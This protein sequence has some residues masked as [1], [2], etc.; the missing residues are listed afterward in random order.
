MYQCTNCQTI[1]DPSV[2]DEF[3]SIEAG[4]FFEDLPETYCCSV[5]D[6]PLSEFQPTEMEFAEKE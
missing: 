5:C 3:A 1:Y 6:A 4:T 2:G